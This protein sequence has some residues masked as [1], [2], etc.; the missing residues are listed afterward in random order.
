[1]FTKYMHLERIGTTE[2]EG[3]EDGLCYV[4]PKLDGTN[5]SVWMV[6]GELQAGSRNRHL[7]IDADN[8]GFFAWAIDQS[9]LKQYLHRNPT[10]ILYGE[11]LVPHSLKTYRDDAWRRF[12]VFDVLDTAT[13]ALIHYENYKDGLERHGIDYL[14]PIAQVKNG[15]LEHFMKCLD[16]NVYLIKDGQGVGEGVVIKNYQWQNKY[17]RVTW[18]KLVGNAFKEEHA[19]A[20]GVAEIGGKVTEERIVDDFVTQHLVDKVYAKIVNESDGWQSRFIPRLLGEVW[21]DLVAEEIW[22]IVKK[23]K[24]PKI[25]F[26]GLLRFCNMKVKALRPDVFQ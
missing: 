13:G 2:V 22:E 16:R 10:H 17:G 4:F 26:S 7:S 5:A 21:H 25:D 23:Y 19:K 9:N 24:N 1:M 11:W 20:M 15:S 8:A 3:I 6:D 18:A 12:Y 14:A